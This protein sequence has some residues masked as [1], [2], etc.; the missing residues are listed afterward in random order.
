MDRRKFPQ[1]REETTENVE[2]EFLTGS[3]QGSPLPGAQARGFSQCWPGV[4]DQWLLVI[5]YLLCGFWWVY[6]LRDHVAPL[7]NTYVTRPLEIFLDLLERTLHHRDVL[8]FEPE[9]EV[10]ETSGCLLLWEWEQSVWKGIVKSDEQR[11]NRDEL[12]AYQ[13]M[14]GERY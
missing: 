5:H 1:G 7:F 8:D 2:K 10:A 3:S 14:M 9:A 12:D 6:S 11:M 13:K 4:W